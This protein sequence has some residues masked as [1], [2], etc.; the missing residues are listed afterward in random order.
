MMKI[1]FNVDCTPAEARAFFGLPDMSPVNEMIVGA[2]VERSK[3]NLDTLSDPKVFWERAMATG[4]GNM[5]AF[6]K[7]FSAGMQAAAGEPKKD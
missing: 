5:E 7:M 3:E 4:T 2:M 6:S 1:T